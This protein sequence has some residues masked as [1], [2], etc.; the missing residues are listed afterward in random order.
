M[1]NPKIKQ[2][3]R[4]LFILASIGSLYFVPW[5]LVKAWITPLPD[6]VQEQLEEGISHGFDGM[7]VY[8]DQGGKPP[9]FYAAGW[10]DREKKI[11]AY[12][13]ALFKIASISKLYVAVAVAKLVK[14]GR[15]SLDRTVAE[16]FPELEGRIENADKITLRML[17]QH[18]SGIPDFTRTP[19]YWEDPPQANSDNLELV[20]DKPADFSPD[21]SY[22]YSN[23]NY[24]LIG[25]ILDETLGY[26]H[27]Q[28]IKEEI[29]IPLKLNN[30]YSLLSE[31][32][33]KDAVM[34]G[35]YVGYDEDM[36]NNNF[37]NPAGSMVATAE[38]VGI[39]LRALNDGSV[40]NEGEQEIYSSI[41]VYEHTGLLPGYQSIAKYHKD[42]DTVVIQFNNT[43]N[44]DGYDWGLAE[45]IY[46]RVV[47]IVRRDREE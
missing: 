12:P 15:L 5:V 7:I 9:E 42:I 20:L 34:S 38:D 2:T 14:E 10:H 33:D 11:P 8:V 1:P 18:R 47:K 30:T 21:K 19:N 26:S 27:H 25:E 45:I 44:F 6:T 23:T 29:L 16:F 37:I 28:Y 35:Y 4:I 43:T 17:V 3:L 39:F 31:V 24:L 46:N 13:Q 40:F 36:K 41:Y 22:G 32:D